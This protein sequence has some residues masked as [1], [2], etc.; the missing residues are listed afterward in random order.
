MTDTPQIS[1]R[2]LARQALAAYKATSR[3]APTNTPAK[4]KKRRALRAGDGRDPVSL[5]AAIKGLSAEVPMEAGVAGGSITD[6]WAT[7]CPQYVGHIEPAGYDE[8][9]GRL[10]LRPASHTYASQLRLLGGQLAKQINNKLGR[11]VVRTIRVL[12]VGKIAAPEPSQGEPDRQQP[13]APVKTREDAHPG[14]RHVLA[15]ALENR[16]EQPTG[17]LYEE[18]ARQRQT[19]ALRANRL[20]DTL[21]RERYWAEQDAAE[22]AGPA[23]GSMAAS[24]AAARAFKRRHQAGQGSVRRAF[25]VA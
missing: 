18:E 17:N 24:E 2:D 9:T 4:A 25:D 13:E 16:Y 6:Q 1:G 11:P 22:A 8:H 7:L 12:P 19:A 14:Y 21:D 5:A 15:L 20:P 10:D 23:A 3:T